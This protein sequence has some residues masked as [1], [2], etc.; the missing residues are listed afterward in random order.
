MYRAA[1][2][3]LTVSIVTLFIVTF[4]SGQARGQA[5][6][7][8][9]AKAEDFNRQG[10]RKVALKDYD[11]AIGLF[12]KSIAVYPDLS[13]AHLNLGSTLTLADRPSEAIQHIKKGLQLNPAS[14]IGFNQ[15]GVAFEKIGKTDEAVE[16]FNT[17]IRLKPDYAF[18]YLNM[19]ATYLWA[20]KDKKALTAL[21][22]SIKLDPNST[23]AHLLLGIVYARL[24]RFKE[25]SDQV[26]LVTRKDPDN[27]AANLLLCQI[28]LMNDDRQ[29][30][31]N[32]Y[33]S[34][35][36]VN[37]PLADAMFKSIFAGKVITVTKDSILKR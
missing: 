4:V 13:P 19:G 26:G 14:I 23:E 25:A 29:A 32:L 30:A 12:Q 28:Y 2:I 9:K 21:E 35:K 8:D 1:K 37:L 22:K 27:E 17:A 18:A 11:S 5:E 33:Q 16:A 31:L 34:F 6:Q 10:I 15:L 20:D 36:A 7:F 24:S 3:H